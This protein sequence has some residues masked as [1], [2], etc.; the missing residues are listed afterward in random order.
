MIEHGEMKEAHFDA[1][2][3]PI[4][5]GPLKYFRLV[6]ESQSQPSRFT[7]MGIWP[8]LWQASRSCNRNLLITIMDALSLPYYCLNPP[9]VLWL[10]K[11]SSG[12]MFCAVQT[13]QVMRLAF[14]LQSS[15]MQVKHQALHAFRSMFAWHAQQIKSVVRKHINCFAIHRFRL[16]HI[17]CQHDS[18]SL[19]CVHYMVSRRGMWQAWCCDVQSLT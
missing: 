4:P 10:G 3:K 9:L 7:S 18:I 19:C 17:Y 8:T 16:E 5:L 13:C 2:R 11:G 1:Y 14:M 12:S 15:D 6:T